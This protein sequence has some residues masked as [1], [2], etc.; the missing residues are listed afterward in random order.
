[1]RSDAAGRARRR[2][3][4]RLAADAAEELRWDWVGFRGPDD[5]AALWRASVDPA[6]HQ[7]LA[8]Y[9]QTLGLWYSDDELAHDDTGELMDRQC[10]LAEYVQAGLPT[11]LRALHHAGDIARIFGH[12]IP[13][14]FSAHDSH[15]PAW[16]WA[17]E[18][19][20]PELYDLFGPWQQANWSPG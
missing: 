10:E 8:N 4:P 3:G 16:E 20:P 2:L 6:G 9:A 14:T 18:A 17:R 1:M 15:L 12:A 5:A 7:L 13:T 11:V 19:N